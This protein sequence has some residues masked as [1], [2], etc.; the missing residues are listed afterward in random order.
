MSIHHLRSRGWMLLALGIALVAGHLIL[1]HFLL[2]SGAFHISIL[3]GL[4][5]GIALLIIAKHLGLLGVLVRSLF[6]R[7]S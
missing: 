5:A 7:R 2:R 4:A 3:S 6:R 1:F